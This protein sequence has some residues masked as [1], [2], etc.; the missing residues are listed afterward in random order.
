MKVACKIMNIITAVYYTVSCY[1]GGFLVHIYTCYVVYTSYGFFLGIISFFCPVIAEIVMFLL[2]LIFLGLFNE[3]CIVII[4]YLLMI[5]FS[6]LL[7]YITCYF[8]DKIKLKN[9]YNITTKQTIPINF[10]I[11]KDKSVKLSNIVAQGLGVDNIDEA[12]SMS[13][14][15]YKQ[16][17]IDM[18]SIELNNTNKYQ[19]LSQIVMLG[20]ETNNIDDAIEKT[21]VFYKEQNKK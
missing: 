4:G 18:S 14:E 2:Y 17:G 19:A 15:F 6:F 20:L 12:L 3:Y 8:E 10:G 11:D 7:S 9:N 13:Y 16:Q 1:F 5:A 21:I